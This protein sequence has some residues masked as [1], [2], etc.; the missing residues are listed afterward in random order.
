MPIVTFISLRGEDQNTHPRLGFALRCFANSHGQA[1][2]N[3]EEIWRKS[4]P[5][6]PSI[7]HPLQPFPFQQFPLAN[8]GPLRPPPM[9]VTIVGPSAGCWIPHGP[10]PLPSLL[11][12]LTQSPWG[13]GRQIDSSAVLTLYFPEHPYLIPDC[14][15]MSGLTKCCR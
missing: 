2:R 11:E 14:A 5:G 9:P 6:N 3:T 7:R 1:G 10:D 15:G 4:F 8:L 13:R 12:L